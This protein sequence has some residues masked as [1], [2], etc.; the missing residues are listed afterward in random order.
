ME[1]QG[2]TQ[3]FTSVFFLDGHLILRGLNAAQR[4]ELSRH[5]QPYPHFDGVDCGAA[6]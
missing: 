3:D 4:A 1:A 2:Q 5:M 6:T